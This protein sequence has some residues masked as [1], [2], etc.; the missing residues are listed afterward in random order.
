MKHLQPVE[1]QALKVSKCYQARLQ[2]NMEA[3]GEIFWW[4]HK[5]KLCNGKSL[6]LPPPDLHITTDASTIW[7]YLQS[8]QLMITAEYLPSHLNVKVD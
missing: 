4:I 2:F 8:K 5:S 3:K 7:D 1:I 6:F